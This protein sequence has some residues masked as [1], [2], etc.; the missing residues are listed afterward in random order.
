MQVSVSRA[1]LVFLGFLRNVSTE[2]KPEEDNRAGSLTRAFV[3]GGACFAQWLVFV[4]NESV[5]G[6]CLPVSESVT[7]LTL[8]QFF[9]QH[10]ERPIPGCDESLKRA[11]L[12]FLPREKYKSS[13]CGIP[14][15]EDHRRGFISNN[16]TLYG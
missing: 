11:F 12:C 15:S 7:V 5:A 14:S 3:A 10:D 16:W 2:T 1:V 6:A 4:G 9:P 8:R 13:R